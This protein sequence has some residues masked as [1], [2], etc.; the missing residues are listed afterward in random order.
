MK[1]EISKNYK[2]MLYCWQDSRTQVLFE[3]IQWLL[4]IRQ[5]EL[6]LNHNIALSVRQEAMSDVSGELFDGF[7]DGLVGSS[8]STMQGYMIYVNMDR[9]RSI[10]LAEYVITHELL[11]IK[12][13]KKT[14]TQI[15]K[16]AASIVSHKKDVPRM[17]KQ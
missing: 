10:Q 7:N 13:P 11:H 14:E 12:F 2:R 15:R 5:K 17:W 6:G 8:V 9:I 4:P 16:I 3:F 1:N